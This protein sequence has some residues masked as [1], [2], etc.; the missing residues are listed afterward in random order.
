[1]TRVQPRRD[2]AEPR[3]AIRTRRPRGFIATLLVVLMM[4]TGMVS[5]ALWTSGA[6]LG[7]VITDGDLDISMGRFSWECLD[8]C[9][10]GTDHDMS[11]LVL[12]GDER[13]V[14][15]QELIT[16]FVGDNLSVAISAQFCPTDSGDCTLPAGVSAVWHL[17]AGST[18]TADVPMTEAILIPDPT[19]VG[20]IVVVATLQ[21][22]LEPSWVDPTTTAAPAAE[23]L[24]LGVMTLTA[25]QVRCGTG[26]SV[27]CPAVSF[28]GG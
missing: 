28:G 24:E 4:S 11:D 21:A 22:L 18:A 27:S 14:L 6:T 19:K 9:G 23:T 5:Y 25:N 15:R 12:R 1:M 2:V 3:R 20:T 8:D 7:A 10:N 26:F 17:E 16:H 13:L